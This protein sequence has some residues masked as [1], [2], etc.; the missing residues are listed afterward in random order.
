[1]S[2]SC[3]QQTISSDLVEFDALFP[4][5]VNI[6]TNVSD[7][8]KA[9]EA[10]LGWFKK[11]CIYN[12]P[13]INRS[14]GLTVASVYEQLVPDA[15]REDIEVAR[16]LGWCV[17]MLRAFFFMIDDVLDNSEEREGKA[18]WYKMNGMMAVNDS[19]FLETSVYQLL[20][21]YTS[22]K[23][24]YV[25]LLELFLKTKRT[26]VIGQ[27]M[28]MLAQGPDQDLDFSRFN[29]NNYS[30]VAR[31]K[32]MACLPVDTAM[33]LACFTD[34]DHLSKVRTVLLEI[35]LFVQIE[36]DYMDCFGDPEVP[37]QFGNDIEER[38]CT[39]LI[40]R[41][42]EVATEE[43]KKD[44]MS[45]YNRCHQ[46]GAEAVSKVKRLYRDLSLEELFQQFKQESLDKVI[47]MIN[48]LETKIPKS[49]LVGVVN[50]VYK[51]NVIG[52]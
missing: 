16:V 19:V 49:V 42:L 2:S 8:D 10:A 37:G 35:G 51:T 13:K 44:L 1:M 12:V 33:I 26:T 5:L 47:L 45:L 7:Q 48:S 39:W 15:S 11:V 17:E 29:M 28:D 20:K 34:E 31:W 46:D 23:A 41:A 30:A 14:S 3:E 43:Q 50:A 6:V 18:C 21:I 4:R 22:K 40:V 38:K 27:C 25:P 32:S 9:A 36:D 24:Y 52:Y